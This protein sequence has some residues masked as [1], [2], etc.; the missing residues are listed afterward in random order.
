MNVSLE[1]LKDVPRPKWAHFGSRRNFE[2]AEKVREILASEEFQGTAVQ[3]EQVDAA[4]KQVTGNEALQARVKEILESPMYKVLAGMKGDAVRVE[5]V[6]E[7]VKVMAQEEVLERPEG[8][9]PETA[10]AAAEQTPVDVAPEDTVPAKAPEETTP[11]AKEPVPTPAEAETLSKAPTEPLEQTPEV[12]E[13]APEPTQ[14]E[15]QPED[16][17]LAN[18]PEE[19]APEVPEATPEPEALTTT[20]AK[21][22]EQVTPEVFEA[23]PEPAQVETQPEDE[24]LANL[25]SESAEATPEPA[26]AEV[27]PE[28]QIPVEEVTPEPTQVEIKPEDEVLANTPVEPAEEATPE[29]SEANSEQAKVEEDV[30][31]KLEILVMEE[32]AKAAEEVRVKAVKESKEAQAQVAEEDPKAAEPVE[33]VSEEKKEKE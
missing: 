8:V 30:Q 19:I 12:S 22:V 27:I 20:P 9:A 7:K 28:A 1:T 14:V 15:T 17:V 24:V 6:Q 2:T 31:V 33:T 32:A 16:K 18:V 10:E 4:L 11:E 3:G 21:P 23:A 5:E 26:Q 29:V 25:S 13:A